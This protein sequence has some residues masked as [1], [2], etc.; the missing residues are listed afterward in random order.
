MNARRSCFVFLSAFPFVV[1]AF[2]SPRALRIPG[3]HQALGAVVFALGAIAAWILG[4]RR[5]GSDQEGGPAALAGSLLLLPLLLIALLWVG[6]GPPFQATLEENHMRYEVLLASSIVVACGFVALK[7]ALA[8]A[9]ETRHSTLAFAIGLFGGMAYILCIGISF[10]QV[11]AMMSQQEATSMRGLALYYD[12][13]EFVACLLTYA[14]TAFFALSMGLAGWLG[15]GATRAYVAVSVLFVV[16]LLARGVE[17]PEISAR[18]APWY[19]RPG[20]IAGIPAIP[21]VMPSLLGV[22]ALRSAGRENAS[23]VS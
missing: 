13:L 17:F 15:R 21:W 2:A 3:L 11:L 7:E 8:R 22:V 4:A 19:T 14:A 12:V 1:L 9:G 10:A 20:V 23:S 5:I 16:L 18:S 6:I